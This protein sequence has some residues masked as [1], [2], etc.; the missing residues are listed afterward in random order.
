MS[1]DIL[2]FFS[3]KSD[4]G[5]LIFQSISQLYAFLVTESCKIKSKI[6]IKNNFL[7]LERSLSGNGPYSKAAMRQAAN[8]HI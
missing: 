5:A 1:D 3:P 7:G 6:C 4:N 8:T 2:H